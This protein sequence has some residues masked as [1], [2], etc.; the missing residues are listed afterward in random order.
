[1]PVVL[2]KVNNYWDKNRECLYLIILEYGKEE[3]V[4]KEAHSS[5]T[6]L[7]VET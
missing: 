7:Q 1:M 6:D 4:L 3:I 5:I 2:G